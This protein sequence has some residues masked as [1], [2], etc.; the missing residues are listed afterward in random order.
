MV[1]IILFSAA[2]LIAVG[3]IATALMRGAETLER[4][5]ET[6]PLVCA[7]CGE[8]PDPD[9]EWFARNVMGWR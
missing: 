2:L 3:A 8:D 7:H 6:E 4:L 5:E 1:G 9:G